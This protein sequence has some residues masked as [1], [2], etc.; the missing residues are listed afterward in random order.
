[1][2][3]VMKRLFYLFSFLLLSVGMTFAQTTRVTGKVISSEDGEPVVGATIVVK[4]TTTGTITN[5]D[6]QFTLD[7]PSSAKTLVVSY[8]GM[9]AKEVAV[10]KSVAVKLDSDTQNLD[11]VVVTA[12]GISREKK[13][14]GYALQEVKSD[15]LTNA[16]QVNVTSA[17]EGKVAGVQVSAS[18]GQIGASSRIVIRGNSSLGDNQPLIVVD[19]IPVSNDQIAA[20]S[21]D[22]GSGINDINPNDIESISVL[23]GGSAALYG[24]RAGN[25]VI[26]I[27]T[28]SGKGKSGIQ[29]NYDGEYTFDHVMNL[30]KYQNKYGEGYTG[31]EYDYN[32]GGYTDG[33]GYHAYK[34]MSSSYADFV[35]KFCYSFDGTDNASDESW[36]PRLDV[37]LKI[38]QFDS[39]IGADGKRI[40]TDWVSHPNN[41]K[42]FFQTGYT[43]N[44]VISLTSNTDKST[45]RASLGYR[46]Q[47]GYIPNTDQARYSAQLN[48]R[49]S[50]GKLVDYD[51]ATNFTYTKSNNLPMTEYNAGNVLQSITQWFGR[52]VN[53]KSLKDNWNTVDPETGLPYSWNPFYHQDPYYTVHKNVNEYTRNRFF[54]KSSLWLKPTDWLK[55]EGR[56]GYDY[57]NAETFSKTAYNTDYPTGFF[58]LRDQK[59]TE[60]N[61]DFVAYF[62]KNVGDLNINMIAGANYRDVLWKYSRIYSDQLTVPELF[63][64]ANAESKTIEMNHSHIRSNSVYG[65]LSLGYKNF[66][67]SDI[68]ARN[69]WSS[70]I[71]DPFFYPSISASFI[72]TSAF[73]ELFKGSILNYLKIR[74]GWA[75]I[76]NATTAYQTAAYYTSAASTIGSVTQF[77]LPTTYPPKNLKPESVETWELGL[78]GNLFNSRLGFDLAYYHKKTTDE[79]MQVTTSSATGYNAMLINAGKIT[80]KGMEVQLNGTPIKTKD[81]AW[82]ITFNWSKDKSKI[83]ELYTDPTTGQS[84]DQYEL[85]H[86]WSTYVYAKPG[87]SWGSIYG[88]GMVSDGKG[89]YIVG[90]DGLPE[91]KYEKLGDVTPDWLA[92]LRNEVT[93]KNVSAG[94]MLDY[95]KGGDIF[96]VSSMWGFYTGILEA[97][98]KGD[99]RERP[100][101]VGKDV[102]TDYS[103]V[104]EDGSAN[105]LTTDA[106]S[107]FY[108]YYY[109]RQLSTFEG[110]FLKLREMHLT[111]SVPQTYLKKIGGFV[112]AANLSIVGNNV[113]ILWLS[114]TNKAHIDPE[115]SSASGSNSGSANYAVGLESVS[116]MPTRSIGFKIGLTF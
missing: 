15:E 38:P 110:S 77:Y 22:Y 98:A 19:G 9:K 37:G 29:I 13:S 63:T 21:V 20:G 95:R 83:V 73:S 114:S 56:L 50:L 10:S 23:K 103:F 78:E 51:L 45:T 75:K 68:S 46:D 48:T 34:D 91:T 81:W 101:V 80:N 40:A 107:F 94:F 66:L 47:N 55:F 111:Y 33:S 12:M 53:M 86:Q 17:L 24:M 59:Q 105:D 49:M 57:Y 100:I 79:I 90:S 52:Q 87:E 62:N 112:K 65:N 71:S 44:H 69:D 88:Y 104:K 32:Y 11:E 108:S 97:T 92:S 102:A 84:L 36:G 64:V 6:G 25:G 27:T 3:C 61:A 43:M 109:N 82:N 89:H 42:S 1:M 70:T 14:L 26:L 74:G 93:W 5:Y 7:V 16:G 8:I 2:E 113:A 54:G 18:G 115:S 99:I 30:P 72:P 96:S 116:Y 106:H 85:G 28:K 41:V 39:P 31:S 35:S 58:D 60:V 67:Y 76:G 4:G